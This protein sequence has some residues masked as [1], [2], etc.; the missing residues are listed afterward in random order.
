[1]LSALPLALKL[2][3]REG[4]FK[5]KRVI[6]LS[7]KCKENIPKSTKHAPKKELETEFSQRKCEHAAKIVN[8]Y[9][10][11]CKVCKCNIQAKAMFEHLHCP[12]GKW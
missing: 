7:S 3:R 11:F 2:G 1:M 10:S 6:K 9:V 8:G 4:I 12:I 5:W